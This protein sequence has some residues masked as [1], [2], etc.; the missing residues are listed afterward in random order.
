MTVWTAGQPREGWLTQAREAAS[1][2]AYHYG[3]LLHLILTGT[4]LKG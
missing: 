3:R 1:T 4:D 2:L